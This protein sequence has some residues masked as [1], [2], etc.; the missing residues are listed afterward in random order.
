MILSLTKPTDPI[1]R[2][3]TGVIDLNDI[4][5][6]KTIATEMHKFVRDVNAIGLAAPQVGLNLRLFVLNSVEDEITCINPEIIMASSD[7]FDNQEG[8]LSFPGLFLKV[9]RPKFVNAS[10]INLDGIRVTQQLENEVTGAW[11]HEFDH[12]NGMLFSDRVGKVSLMMAR[13]RAEKLKRM[14]K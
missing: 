1:L 4:E 10:W 11:M 9:P 6:L 14:S 13:K 7:T 3:M 8:C 2:K 5:S 12:V